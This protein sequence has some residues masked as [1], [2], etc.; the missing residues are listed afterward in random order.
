MDLKRAK[1]IE[2]KTH[3]FDKDYRNNKLKKIALAMFFINVGVFVAL[4]AVIVF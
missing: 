3:R 1:M 2:T 4:A